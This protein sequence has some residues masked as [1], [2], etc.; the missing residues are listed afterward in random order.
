MSKIDEALAHL[1]KRTNKYKRTKAYL[2]SRARP[3]EVKKVTYI[4]SE[5]EN[6]GLPVEGEV[7]LEAGMCPCAICGHEFM[8]ECEDENC[9]CC[10]STCN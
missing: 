5:R 10:T 8:L 9:E 6:Y 4:H 3:L 2:E 7:E 1:D